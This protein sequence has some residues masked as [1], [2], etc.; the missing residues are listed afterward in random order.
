M[1]LFLNGRIF[2]EQQL[3]VVAVVLT[4]LVAMYDLQ[5]YDQNIEKWVR[6]RAQNYFIPRQKFSPTSLPSWICSKAKPRGMAFWTGKFIIKFLLFHWN[7]IRTIFQHWRLEAM[8]HRDRARPTDRPIPCTAS[9]HR[10]FQRAR[11][12]GQI[13][14]IYGRSCGDVSRCLRM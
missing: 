5:S 6:T 7:K 10:G 8:K 12:A 13:L 2:L 9:V 11:S 3:R 4:L 1:W 14:G